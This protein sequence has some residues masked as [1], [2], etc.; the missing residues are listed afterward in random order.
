M[1]Q[2]R[3]LHTATHPP[4][5]V[6]T[7]LKGSKHNRRVTSWPAYLITSPRLS[8]LPPAG[9]LLRLARAAGVEQISV[10]QERIWDGESGWASVKMKR[11]SSVQTVTPGDVSMDF[12]E[13]F[14]SDRALLTPS[15]VI[16]QKFHILHQKFAGSLCSSHSKCK[17][18]DICLQ[19]QD[20]WDIARVHRGNVLQSIRGGQ[21]LI[22]RWLYCTQQTALRQDALQRARW[23]VCV[24]TKSNACERGEKR[25]RDINRI[26]KI[27]RQRLEVGQRLEHGER[28]R[29]AAGGGC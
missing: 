22:N 29:G 26:K 8:L 5:S 28:E 21:W 11:S 27:L 6:G 18:C 12:S 1:P 13:P 19:Q 16:Y 4:D 24:G 20:K 15:A 23:C 7:G 2:C 3:L 17:F 14:A 9:I 25:K 10:F